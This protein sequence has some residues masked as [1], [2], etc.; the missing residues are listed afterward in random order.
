LLR[1]FEAALPEPWLSSRSCKII[2]ICSLPAHD[3]NYFA[4]L[5]ILI[6]TWELAFWKANALGNALYSALPNLLPPKMHVLKSRF[7]CVSLSLSLS[8]P[9]SPIDKKWPRE[10]AGQCAGQR[11]TAHVSI[12]MGRGKARDNARDSARIAKHGP[13]GNAGQCAGQRGTAD[14]SIKVVRGNLT[15]FGTLKTIKRGWGWGASSRAVRS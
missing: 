2:C 4:T 6:V 11:G 8:L 3:C 7:F 12:N 5:L 1:L 10:S 14:V 13:Q 15:P 9:L